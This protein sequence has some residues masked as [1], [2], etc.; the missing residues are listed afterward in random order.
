MSGFEPPFVFPSGGGDIQYS[1]RLMGSAIVLGNGQLTSAAFTPGSVGW[2]ILGD[3]SVEFNSGN[4]RGDIT[5]ASGTFTGTVTARSLDIPDAVSAASAHIDALGNFW[6]GATTL[7]AAPFSV[8]NAGVAV[9]SNLTISGTS[10]FSGAL[11]AATGTFAGSLSAAT[12]TFGGSLSAATGT[13]AGSLTAATGTFAGSISAASGT[14]T[15]DLSGSGISGGTID[16]GGSDASSFHVDATGNIWSG[17]AN[18]GDAPFRVSAAGAVVADTITLTMQSASITDSLIVENGFAWARIRNTGSSGVGGLRLSA[19]DPITTVADILP[20]IEFNSD[21]DPATLGSMTFTAGTDALNAVFQFNGGYMSVQNSFTAGGSV[22][23]GSITTSGSVRAASGGV[24]GG[25]VMRSWTAGS[26]QMSL[27]T[28]DMGS[29]ASTLQEYVVLTNG[30]HTYL[31]SGTGGTTHIRGGANSYSSQIQVSA[32]AT[33]VS[34][35][36]TLAAITATEGGELHFNPGTHAAYTL[37]VVIDSYANSMRIHNGVALKLVL[38]MDDGV[39]DIHGR[40]ISYVGTM[41][42]GGSRND[43]GFSWS[44]PNIYGHVDGVVSAVIGT[45]SDRRLKEDIQ[46]VVGSDSLAKV[47]AYRPI[48]Y[49]PIDLDGAVAPGIG[50]HTGMIADEVELIDATLVDGVADNPDGYQS[51]NYAG[52][53]PDLVQAFQ[54]LVGRLDAAGL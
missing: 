29:T 37:P 32:S 42:G 25:L 48:T 10:T 43:V 23:A 54:G 50:R 15:G 53:I 36:L 9:A 3:G 8:T 12:G 52:V 46:P 33:T 45:V 19:Y 47:M 16:I 39:L 28:N 4:F 41:S 6:V 5:G 22:T 27:A 26:H 34:G 21:S 30:I 31:G 35:V 11:T 24:D 14:F 51:V 7:G 20:S 17:H 13:F 40:G 44:S 1:T 18:Y 2:G 49:L 38:G